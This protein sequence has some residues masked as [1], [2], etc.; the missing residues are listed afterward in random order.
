MWTPIYEVGETEMGAMALFFLF[1]SEIET[2]FENDA[3][4]K[5]MI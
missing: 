2:E 4:T 5:V 1:A 3:T